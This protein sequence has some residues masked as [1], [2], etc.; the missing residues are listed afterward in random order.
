MN[1]RKLLNLD[2]KKLNFKFNE[3]YEFHYMNQFYFHNRFLFQNIGKVSKKIIG[4]LCIQ[5]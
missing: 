2:K 5:I 3:L 4:Q 1:M